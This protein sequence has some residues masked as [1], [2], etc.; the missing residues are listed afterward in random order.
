MTKGFLSHTF[1]LFFAL[2]GLLPAKMKATEILRFEHYNTSRGLSQNTATSILCDSK[3]FLWIGTNNGLN[4]FDGNRF[5]VFMNEEGGEQFFT[6]NRII[7]IWE[8]NKGFIWFETHDGHYHYFDPVKETFESLSYLITDLEEGQ[9]VF[10][11]FL[12]YSDNEIWLGLT[13]KG[14]LRLMYNKELHQYD[15]THYTSR[16]QHAITNN[17]VSFIHSDRNGNIWIGTQR[18][19]TQIDKE[20]LNQNHP[21]FSH[22]LISHSFTTM[23]ETATEL[24]FGTRE[25]GI[26]KFQKNSQHY[27]FINTQNTPS[28]KSDNIT[29]LH[30]TKTGTIM[31]AFAQ[32]GVQIFTPRLNQWQDISLRGQQ[33]EQVYEDQQN[34]VWL[35]TE[36]LGITGFNLETAESEFHYFIDPNQ[37]T[38]PDSE[39]HIFYEDSK[40]NLWIGTHEGGLN[41]YD[42]KRKDFRQFKNNP[43]DPHSL[44]TN[45]VMCITEDHSG[46]LWVGTGQFQGSLEKVI[47]K[48]PAFDHL[49]PRAEAG[50]ISD[51]IVRAVFEDP[52]ERIWAATKAGRLHVFQND[53]Q[54]HVFEQFPTNK[55]LLT[56]VNVYTIM[57]DRDGYLWLGS[58]GKGILVSQQPLHRYRHPQEIRFTNYLPEE[59]DPG[60]VSHINIYSLVQDPGGH[61]WVGTYGNG[62]NLGIKQEDGSYRFRRYTTANSTLSSNLVRHV[63]VDQKKRLWVATGYGL[64]LFENNPAEGHPIRIRNFYA[65]MAPHTMSVNDITHLFED[66]EGTLW[67]ATYGGG[68]NRLDSLNRDDAYFSKFDEMDG[69]SNNVVYSITDDSSGNHLWFS[70]ENGLSRFHLRNSTFE[71][72]NSNNGLNFDSF[73]ENTV[74]KTTKGTLL[75]GGFMGIEVI[76]PS[77]IEIPKWNKRAELTNFQ[78]FNKAVP[79]GPDEPLQKSIAYTNEI[80]LK[81]NQ[82]SFS[83]EFS[84]M[85]YMDPVKTQY[86]YKLDEF[87]PDWNIVSGDR[88]AI[89]TNLSPGK[90]LF[91][92]RATNRQGEWITNQRILRITILPPWYKTTWAFLLYSLLI[93]LLFYI[94]AT[95]VAKINQYRNELQIE[96]RVNEMKLRFFTNISHEIR[97]PLTLILGP[98]EDMLQKD[99]SNSDK[100]R[101]E[102]IRKNGK[103]MLQLT[104]QL[105]DFR[106][107]QNNKMQLKVRPFELVAFTRSIYESFE[108]LAQHKKI[109]Y[110]FSTD[111][112]RCEVWA[113]PTKLDT[114]IYNLLSNA[115]KFTEAEKEVRLHLAINPADQQ[116]EITV[117]DQ[118]RGI[119]AA[120]LSQLF[121]RY[122][123]LSGEELAG[124]GIGL[125][126]SNELAR[127]HHGEIIVASEENQGSTFTLRLRQGKKH[128]EKDQRIIWCEQNDPI[129]PMTE[130]PAEEDLTRGKGVSAIADPLDKR[131]SILVV[132]DN[133]EIGDYICR[134]LSPEF[135]TILAGNGQEALDLLENQNPDL[136]VSDIMMPV[137]DGMEMTE[138]IKGNFSTS[139]IP[140]ILLTAKSGVED[141]IAGVE[142]GADAYLVKPF[143]AGYL[144]AM[145]KNLIEQRRNVIAKFR[146][147]KTIDP[148]TLKVN[149]KDEEFLQKLISYVEENHAEDF[150]IEELADTL[151]V[152]RTVF[153]NK[154]KGLTGLS[155]VEFVRQ[156]KL[157]I[158]AHLLTQGY[159]VSEA[160]IKVGFNDARYFSRQFKALFGYLPSKHLEKSKEG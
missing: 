18:G 87:D 88:R 79:I 83:F 3:G 31:A 146:D 55:G 67:L 1:I 52:Q 76:R 74:Y 124:T 43:Q 100:P 94:I 26:L 16:G 70:T 115:L 131:P 153:Y 46:Q 7:N 50:H 110:H 109:A 126:L 13:T 92:V 102:I 151:C 57:M 30:I 35:T 136:I 15:V 29:H 73:S 64:N 96:K 62:L 10:T 12:Q 44:S 14:V 47:L 99:L 142:L 134:S 122:T 150:T 154:V 104:N 59:N 123:I 24:W 53:R 78:L 69:L 141:Q 5:R 42:R 105:L 158:A 147:N 159:N 77:R 112:E 152:S 19:L 45:I 97:T 89:Y 49:L 157:K 125:S 129:Q 121:E 32:N 93:G 66:K 140:I 36:A 144:K 84:S 106:K 155:P 21:V 133:P 6:H 28:L 48:D 91:R 86:A 139:H 56:G 101:L 160:A 120:N 132:E 156:L 22:L 103:R 38:L 82:N 130:L 119:A 114:I 108:P 138:K 128:F 118:G 39:R 25:D 145:V 90:Y 60:S 20:S 98:I 17:H 81:H 51:N 11:E 111:L 37:S 4:R 143:N 71:I 63:L 9:S 149:S 85:D 127:L 80:T 68:I 33:I 27:T 34:M 2:N 23:V 58:K 107:I 135:S 117:S 65:S 40:G 113:D 95:T 75:F 54:I 116:I 148:S 8:D 137:M 41:L 61:I 72:F